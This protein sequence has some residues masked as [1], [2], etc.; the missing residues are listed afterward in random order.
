M[1][2]ERRNRNGA[3]GGISKGSKSRTDVRAGEG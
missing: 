3:A 1:D 2:V